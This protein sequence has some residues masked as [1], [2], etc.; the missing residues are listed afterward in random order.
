M[1]WV[2][3]MLAEHAVALVQQFLEARELAG[4][5]AP[6][7]EQRELEPAFVGEVDGLEELLR[8]GG[9]DEHRHAEAAAHRPDGVEVGVVHAQARAVGLADAQA[10][11]LEDLETARAG[12]DVTF[13]LGGG[14]LRPAGRADALEVDV[15]EQDHAVLVR[16]L[17]NRVEAFAESRTEA[18]AQVDEH[19]QVVGVHP[20][21]H[22][23]ELLGRDRR[24]LVAMNVDDRELRPRHRV[25]L[26]AQRVARLVVEDRRRRKLRRA[27]GPRTP[28]LHPRPLLRHHPDT[29]G[30]TR[31]R[32]DHHRR[33]RT[34]PHTA[35]SHRPSLVPHPRAAPRAAP[36]CRT[37]R[38]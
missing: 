27:P 21:D 2:L 24:R 32:H 7:A 15:G 13:E 28:P 30:A 18:A 14:L 16:A 22:A 23:L 20:G 1:N 34:P 10:E 37:L 31:H 12:L 29:D 19:A 11:V 9:V 8:L 17:G 4:R 36:S 5:V 35:P 38:S 25:F 6:V 33:Y 26:D 3:R